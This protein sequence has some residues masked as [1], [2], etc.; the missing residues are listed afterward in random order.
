VGSQTTKPVGTKSPNELGIY[1]MSGNV[2]ESCSDWYNRSYY[3]NSK[4]D[5]PQGAKSGVQKVLRGGSV[6]NRAEPCLITNRFYA[7]GNRPQRNFGLRVVL[8]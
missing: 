3:K 1:D 8:D 4:S 6:I 2:W 7:Y 5:N